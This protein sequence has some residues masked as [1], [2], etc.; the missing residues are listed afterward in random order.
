VVVTPHPGEMARLTGRSV[1][2]IQGNRVA[3]AREFASQRKVI[4]VLKGH[5]TLIASSDGTVWV[6]AT[7]NPGM[8]TGGTGDVLTGMIA[9]LI[10]QHPEQAL[11]AT[12]LAVYLHGLAG[13]LAC[14]ELGENSLV[15]TDLERFLPKAFSCARSQADSP[16]LIHA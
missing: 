15:A 6:N 9:G 7:G 3:V 14:E 5:R 8:A 10:T 1:A 16:V 11:Q 12:A 13:D 4:V 2:D